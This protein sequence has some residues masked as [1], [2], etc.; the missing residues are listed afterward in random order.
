MA[1]WLIFPLAGALLLAGMRMMAMTIRADQIL[2]VRDAPLQAALTVLLLTALAQSSG[3]VITVLIAAYARGDLDRR[4]AIAGVLGANVGTT[5]TAW[6]VAAGALPPWTGAVLGFFL[7]TA[8]CCRTGRVRPALGLG[9]V[10]F[11]LYALCRA[12]QLL[13]ALPQL[14]EIAAPPTLWLLGAGVSALTQS[15]SAAIGAVQVL[16]ASLTARSALWYVAGCNVGTCITALC[17][18]AVTNRKGM[19]LAMVQLWFNL[20][21]CAIALVWGCT[22][23][24]MASA[25]RIAEIHTI[26][27]G[28]P[29]VI[30]LAVLQRA[31]Q[32]GAKPAKYRC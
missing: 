12:A 3:A 21:A 5:S 30:W 26:F 28:I 1:L 23:S 22:L 16:G 18:G 6:L 10:L 14:D 24:G 25:W 4:S 20:C 13:G 17:A 11:S 29:A 27:N 15:S 19:A 8:L 32:C 9:L 2:R 7:C 31:P